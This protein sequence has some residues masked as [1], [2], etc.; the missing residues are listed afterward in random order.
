MYV[1]RIFLGMHLFLCLILTSISSFAST[2]SI[3]QDTL[4]ISASN[5]ELYL[6]AGTFLSL[7]NAQNSQKKLSTQ[8]GAPVKIVDIGAY[9]V[10]RIGPMQTREEG[11][12]LQRALASP[13][14]SHAAPVIHAKANVA[15]K[16]TLDTSYQYFATLSA[17]PAWADAGKTQTFYLQPMTQKSYVADKKTDVIAVVEIFSGAQHPL[18]YGVD[19]QL[20]LAVVTAGKVKLS[21]SV[22]DDALPQFNNFNYKYNIQHTHIAAK[23]KLLKDIEYGLKPYISGSLGVGFNDARSFSATPTIFEA[24]ATPS[25]QSNTTTAFVYTAG[26]GVQRSVINQH[27]QA[28][29][30]YEFADWGKSQLN[31]S[32]E[33][34]MGQ[35]LSLNHLYINSLQFSLSYFA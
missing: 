10:V 1:R 18:K 7:S 14:S 4:L 11:K 27:W 19:G 5:G 23:G 34:T 15:S 17:G 25:F 26:V 31:R 21:G 3:N 32:F 30:G 13:V 20:G 35:G 8:V 2:S 9:H 22:W 28:G 16:G 24:V 12:A 33:Q 29:I 6:Q